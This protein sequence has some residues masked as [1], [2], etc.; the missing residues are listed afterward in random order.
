MYVRVCGCARMCVRVC[1]YAP[2]A[3]VCACACVCVH[4]CVCARVC[5][6]ARVRVFAPGAGLVVSVEGL[7]AIGEGRAVR[8][9]RRS[10]AKVEAHRGAQKPPR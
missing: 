4:V 2:E 5:A 3:E 10:A 8:A 6:R 9:A 1:V 7:E